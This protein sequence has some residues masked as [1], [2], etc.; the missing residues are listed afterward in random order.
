MN[1]DATPDPDLSAAPD[2]RRR[3]VRL[4]V[5]LG[6]GFLLLAA[7]IAWLALREDPQRT[8]ERAR[9]L[10]A[11]DPER[12]LRLLKSSWTVRGEYLPAE[13][14]R[15]QILTSLGRGQEAIQ[16]FEKI[17][18][19]S[20][21][22]PNDLLAL[23][24][25]AQQAK[26]APLAEKALLGAYRPGPQQVTV[27]RLLISLTY[28][29]VDDKSVLQYCRE[30]ATLVP[31]DPEPWLVSAGIYH[32]REQVAAALDAYRQALR[33]NPP[34]KEV[35]R[36]R[37]QIAERSLHMGDLAAARKEL[38]LVLADVPA[39]PEYQLLNAKLLRQ[40]G[41]GSEAAAEVDSL[42]AKD[43]KLLDALKLRGEIDFDGGQF[44]RAVED[45]SRVLK[46][47]P[48]DREAHHKLG[49][50]YLR[51]GDTAQGQTHL[52]TARHLT[53]VTIEILSLEHQLEGDPANQQ[54]P[55]RLAELN[56]QRG[57]TE[58][59]SQWRRSSQAS[60]P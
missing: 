33:R 21:C 49:M 48:F 32:E 50:A 35:R 7:V 6:A 51:L 18:D 41:K 22:D 36:V 26:V 24:V 28:E 47:K 16:R 29:K 15:C 42:L 13:L 44:D 27:L 23:A 46:A 45:L 1:L 19:L 5:V 31:D 52:D 9:K 40:E 54:I 14:L 20:A 56:E 38:D 10:Q 3:A 12:A 57:N 55:R 4:A 2:E 34:A 11:S 60:S 25:T 43:P 17:H 30:L 8:V 39:A 53:N 37:Y 58:K 59:A